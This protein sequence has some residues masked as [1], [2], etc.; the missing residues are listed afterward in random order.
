MHMLCHG[1]VV[2]VRGLL[3]VVLAAGWLTL[4]CSSSP[5]PV[6]PPTYDPDAMAAAAIAEY[7]KN[8]DG[9]LD[10]A[11]L[12]HCPGLKIALFN[13]ETE[14]SYLTEEDIAERLRLFQKSKAGL[15]SARCTV[16]RDGKGCPDVTVTFVPEKFMGDAIKP[17]SGISDADGNV[18]IKVAGE[19]FS[20][21]SLGY[22]RVEASL[23]DPS[24]KETLPA[25]FNTDT[26]IGQEVQQRRTSHTR[27]EV[28]S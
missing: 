22:Y 24:G 1:F 10:A 28:D 13:M 27:I 25:R 12:E 23:K 8:G 21:L 17:G 5:A 19:P 4:G 18:D 7:D 16:T 20:G 9:K 2:K 14:K 3:L 26:K 11:E 15:M 6:P